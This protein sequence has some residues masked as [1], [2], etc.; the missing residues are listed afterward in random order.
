MKFR[1]EIGNIE[2]SFKI[3]HNDRIVMLGSCFADNIGERL[4]QDGFNV[5][6][7]PLGP[8]Y[9]PISIHSVRQGLEE[10]TY[11][12]HEGIWHCLSFNNRY[13]DSDLQRLKDRVEAEVTTLK[14]SLEDADIV[15]ITYG[16][17]HVFSLSSI[18]TA[19]GNCH[20]LPT[21]CF[22]EDVLE[23]EISQSWI[24]RFF[25]GMNKRL[26]VTLSPVLYPS[27]GLVESSLSKARL[28]VA[29]E[30]ARK[31][32]GFDYFP[33]FE[34]LSSDLRDYRFYAD[35]LRH[36]SA[37]AVKYIYQHFADT[38]FSDKTKE[39]A[40]RRHKEWLRSQHRPLL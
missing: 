35:D 10:L 26:I 23:A 21:K 14:E 18:E 37:M 4:E 25:A 5:F 6:H 20:K 24:E 34:I 32:I 16:T 8:L 2:G 39:E 15:I 33:S 3:S 11:Y 19:V 29:I 1:T 36:P 28:R 13:Q 22:K 17:D 7:N 12:E 27:Y 9:N 38:Y 30:Q 31:K 40:S